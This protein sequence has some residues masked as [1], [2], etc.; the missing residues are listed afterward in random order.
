[1][2]EQEPNAQGIR[3]TRFVAIRNTYKEL[4]DT[5]AKDWMDTFGTKFGKSKGGG[6]APITWK[7]RFKL[8]DQTWVQ[9]ELLFIALNDEKS[10]KKLRGTQITG[11]WFNEAKEIPKEIL[12][13]ADG[14]H[15]R[16]PGVIQGV[17]ATWHG[18]I[19]DTNSPDEDHWFNKVEVEEKETNQDP[20]KN[21]E[22]FIQPGGIMRDGDKRDYKGR[23]I[24]KPNPDAEN[25]NNLIDGHGYYMNQLK[26]DKDE[27]WVAVNL[28]N[29]VGVVNEGKAIFPLF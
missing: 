2:C 12:N 13:M 20:K 21:W 16:Y 7:G 25:L 29:E 23:Q 8:D 4:E 18:I 14:R 15:G 24:W 27:S 10:D 22:F 9:S 26:G 6:G 11:F 1:M 3:P 17:Q 19:G 5:T 28:G